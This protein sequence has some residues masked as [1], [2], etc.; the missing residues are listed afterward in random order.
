MT[1]P[2]LLCWC[3]FQRDPDIMGQNWRRHH[4]ICHMLRGWLLLHM[5][6]GRLLL[7]QANLV[8]AVSLPTQPLSTQAPHAVLSSLFSG[9]QTVS[10]AVWHG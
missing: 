9:E 8:V 5:V 1:E 4:E 2:L 7:A 3:M 6:C 10:A